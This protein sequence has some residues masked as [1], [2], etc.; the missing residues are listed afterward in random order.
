MKNYLKNMMNDNGF[1]AMAFAVVLVALM[2]VVAIARLGVID[3]QLLIWAGLP[4]LLKV[5]LVLILL[6]F[7]LLW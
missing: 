1:M 5:V 3:T 7:V 4:V 2:S 6:E